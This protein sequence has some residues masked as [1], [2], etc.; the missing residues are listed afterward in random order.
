MA[1]LCQILVTNCCKTQ[2]PIKSQDRLSYSLRQKHEKGKIWVKE[3]IV[4][5]YLNQTAQNTQLSS[6]VEQVW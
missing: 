6:S 2:P 5:N 3:N 1:T 4:Q